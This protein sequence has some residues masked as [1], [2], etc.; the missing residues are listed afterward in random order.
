M[1]NGVAVT[2]GVIRVRRRHENDMDFSKYNPFYWEGRRTT[3]TFEDFTSAGTN[4]LVFSLH[5]EWPQDAT[6]Y[7]GPD[8]SA[9]YIGDPLAHETERSKFAI[10]TRMKTMNK[11]RT[12]FQSVIGEGAFRVHAEALQ[13]GK[14]LVIEAR[15][16][17][18]ESHP[19]WAKQKK[20]NG[21]NLSA[22]YSEFFRV[23]LGKPG[24]LIDNPETPGEPAPPA[25]YAGGWTTT[26]TTRVEPWAALQQQAFNLTP[27]N[28]EAFLIGRTWF[29][30]DFKTGKHVSDKSDDKP[31]KFFEDMETARAGHSA[32]AYNTTS[33][34]QC[35]FHNGRALLPEPGDAIHTTVA[36]LFGRARE[37]HG[38]QLQTDGDAAE[39]K[40]TLVRHETED[41][42]LSD[43]TKVPLSRPVFAIDGKEDL[44]V[45]IRNTPALIGAGLLDAIPQADIAAV[46]KAAGKD[47]PIGRFG[48]KASQPTLVAQIKDALLHDMGVTSEDLTKVDGEYDVG[49]APAP[50]EAIDALEAYVA[51][52]GVP[53]RDVSGGERLRVGRD[54]FQTIGCVDCHRPAWKTGSSKFPEL[55]E[56]VIH[57]YTDLLLHDLGD[58]LA[59]RSGGPDARLWRTAPLWGLKNTRHANHEH[60]DQFRPGDTNLTFKDTQAVASKN[61]VQLLHDGRARSLAEAILWH[62]GEAES[63]TEAY[64][65]LTAEERKALHA[66]VWSL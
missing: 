63:A 64:K 37:A 26:P 51:L 20:R 3:F 23:I 62:G 46:A 41:V 4:K 49:K 18:D 40:L 36:R 30:T 47:V 17:N 32:A 5:T 13:P 19:G 34:N 66:F 59:D 55:A 7:R 12:H 45:S 57:P 14:V 61:R 48:W 2:E 44:T 25:R 38:A 58:G 6:K 31:S 29:H 8:F 33:C 28:A 65:S 42:T 27:D 9:I 16:F 35:H 11:E 21:H 43:G 53:P 39:G 50:A 24:L 22:Y 10:N 60:R 52:L 15:F 1:E 56:Q 54:L